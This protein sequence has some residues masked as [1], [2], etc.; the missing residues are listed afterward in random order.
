[1]ATSTKHITQLT[2]GWNT[3]ISVAFDAAAELQK[4]V[5]EN[6]I[7]EA[8][9]VDG[10][11][12]NRMLSH[13]DAQAEELLHSAIQ[14]DDTLTGIQD[15]QACSYKPDPAEDDSDLEPYSYEDK[16]NPYKRDRATFLWEEFGISS[17]D[18]VCWVIG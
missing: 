14:A 15:D 9:D 18:D 12:I 16:D 6:F 17:E 4:F 5:S 10:R 8:P 3:T 1:M 11:E 7:P 13:L 2:A